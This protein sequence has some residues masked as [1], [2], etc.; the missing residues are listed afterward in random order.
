VSMVEVAAMGQGYR[1]HTHPPVTD[2][3]P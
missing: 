1:C 3:L 2:R